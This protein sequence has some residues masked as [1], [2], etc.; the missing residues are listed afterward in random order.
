MSSIKK[1][2]EGT[3]CF[4]YDV[5]SANFKIRAHRICFPKLSDAGTYS[6]SKQA[7]I[8]TSGFPETAYLDAK[9][10][11]QSTPCCVFIRYVEFEDN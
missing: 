7:V 5:R 2:N 10:F 3:E 8:S 6:Q 11:K 9:I 4:S 1:A